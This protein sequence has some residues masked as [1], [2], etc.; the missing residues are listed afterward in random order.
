MQDALGVVVTI[1]D[2]VAGAN[3]HIAVVLKPA[4]AVVIADRAAPEDVCVVEDDAYLS[5]AR[6]RLHHD[7]P[8]CVVLL[9]VLIPLD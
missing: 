5:V 2:A 8:Q 4:K 7:R 9:V 3:L 1:H 6:E